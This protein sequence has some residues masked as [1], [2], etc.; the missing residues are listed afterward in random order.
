MPHSRLETPA[1]AG[2]HLGGLTVFL[3]TLLLTVAIG[4]SL[5]IAGVAAAPAKDDFPKF[6]FPLGPVPPLTQTT[7]E[8]TCTQAAESR[9]GRYDC[10]NSGGPNPN[11]PPLWL[12]WGCPNWRI[13]CSDAGSAVSGCAGSTWNSDTMFTWSSTPGEAA[14]T[15]AP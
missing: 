1:T 13:T 6:T 9:H 7:I 3:R 2:R 15:G 5:A 10:H 8:M 14:R 12:N 11:P 4:A